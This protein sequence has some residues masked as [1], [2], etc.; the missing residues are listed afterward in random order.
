MKEDILKE[1]I[2]MVC[3]DFVYTLLTGIEEYSQDF[4]ITIACANCMAELKEKNI[5]T[6]F[7]NFFTDYVRDAIYRETSNYLA[8]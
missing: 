5:I 7:I 6:N 1:L 2:V 8:R 3:D 4:P